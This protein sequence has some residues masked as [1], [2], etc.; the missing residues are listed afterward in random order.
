[1]EPPEAV[2]VGVA[3]VASV[4]VPDELDQVRVAREMPPVVYPLPLAI[5]EARPE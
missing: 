4:L 5:S 3:V 1:M 2:H